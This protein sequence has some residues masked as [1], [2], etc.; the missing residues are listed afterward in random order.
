MRGRRDGSCCENEVH[1]EK[2][3]QVRLNFGP[4]FADAAFGAHHEKKFN[5]SIM[6]SQNH[7]SCPRNL[8][9]TDV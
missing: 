1:T 6:K 5:R 9:G 3:K 7:N 2:L 8:I 4:A